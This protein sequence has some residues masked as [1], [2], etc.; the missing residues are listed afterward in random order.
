ME[1]TEFRKRNVAYKLRIGDIL[2]GKPIMEEAKFL[3]LDLNSKIHEGL[4]D[5]NNTKFNWKSFANFEILDSL[6]Y[7]SE[8]QLFLEGKFIINISMY[9]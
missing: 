1:E 2:K 9:H 4:V 8:N 7:V 6:I 3:Y 5:I